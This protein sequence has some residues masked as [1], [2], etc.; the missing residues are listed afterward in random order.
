MSQRAKD[1]GGTISM[2]G[3]YSARSQDDGAVMHMDVGVPQGGNTYTL[4]I[5]EQYS[6][7]T[8]KD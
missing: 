8:G 3:M 5:A 1:G 6:A 7:P 2:D 4:A